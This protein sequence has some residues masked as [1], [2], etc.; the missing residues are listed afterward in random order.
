MAAG[1]QPTTTMP[2]SRHV[3]FRSSGV[4]R[5]ENGLSLWKYRISTAQM[6]PIWM[7]TRKSSKKSADTCSCTNSSTRIMCPVEEMGSHS[8]MPSTMPMSSALSAS[9][10]MYELPWF[11]FS[12][13]RQPGVDRLAASQSVGGRSVN[14]PIERQPARKSG[15]HLL[16]PPLVHIAQTSTDALPVSELYTRKQKARKITD[17]PHWQDDA[18]KNVPV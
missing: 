2:H 16:R 5:D 13:G 8:V 9:M 11:L 6:A 18:G 12:D 10:I 4:L 3:P 14:P 15:S 1:M 7:T 17:S